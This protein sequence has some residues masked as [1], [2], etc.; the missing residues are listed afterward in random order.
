MRIAIDI[1][2]FKNGT[3]GIARYLR[4]ILDHLQKIDTKN[5]YF[6]FECWSSDYFPVN[7]KWKKIYTSWKLPG[8]LWQQFILPFQ[9]RKYNIEVL[10]AP[11]Q[12]CPLFFMKGI[13]IITTVHDIAFIH[14]PETFQPSTLLILKHLFPRVITKSNFLVTVSNYITNDMFSTYSKICKNA[15]V[16]SCT[17]GKPDWHI[18]SDYSAENR[19]DF[20]LFVGNIEPRK[21]LFNLVK[22]L[23]ILCD[24][25][26]NVSLHLVGPSGWKNN[27]LYT[28]IA[29][30]RIK[31]I[32]HFKGYL[33]ED[34]LKNEYLTCKA[35]IYPSLYEGFGL[36]TLEALCLDCLVLTSKETVMEE[37]AKNCA[38]YFDPN[39]SYDIASAIEKIYTANF[40][41]SNYLIDKESILKEYSWTKSAQKL[42][43]LFMS[44]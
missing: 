8:I 11:E 9:L 30:S 37:L 20:L 41:R 29:N 18:P 43:S 23:E 14:Y 5:E 42:L 17:N 16:I 10:W 32:I 27:E 26:F 35:L 24:K 28:Y 19:K 36:P 3:T 33:P 40:N 13:K 7:K 25:G 31:K 38:I 44:N 12:V 22:A 15:N 34:D 21:N 4:S 39:N 6:L 1:K 2:A